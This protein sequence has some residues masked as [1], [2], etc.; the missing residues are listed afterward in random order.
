MYL[1][2][3]LSRSSKFQNMNTALWEDNLFDTR[4][5]YKSYDATYLELENKMIHVHPYPV[6][7]ETYFGFRINEKGLIRLGWV[8]F[9]IIDAGTVKI[10]E[11]AIQKKK[12]L[13]YEH[14]I[15]FDVFINYP[16]HLV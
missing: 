13:T 15:Y 6:N 5:N 12:Y 4:K 11:T 8:K 1:S 3:T 7:K 14:T 9:I 16:S 10:I 2:D